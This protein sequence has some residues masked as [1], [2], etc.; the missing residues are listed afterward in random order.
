MGRS[1]VEFRATHGRGRG[2]GRG[3]TT[4]EH[5]KGHGGGQ[6]SHSRNLGSNA[7]RFEEHED[8]DNNNDAGQEISADRT[9]FFATEQIHRKKMGVAP[10]EYFQSRT[11]KEWEETD[12]IGDGYGGVI[13]VLDFNWIASQLELVAPAIRYRLDPKYCIDLPY[14]SSNATDKEAAKEV[15]GDIAIAA[16]ALTLADSKEDRDLDCLLKLSQPTPSGANLTPALPI[17]DTPVSNDTTITGTEQLE[18]WLDDVLD[19]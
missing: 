2:R 13:A 1:Q 10:G 4:G 11:M 16:E 7:Y 5:R 19:S 8:K 9:Q 18:D 17:L 15:A 6:S 14:E 3:D 12:E